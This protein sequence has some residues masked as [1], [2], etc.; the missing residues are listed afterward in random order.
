MTFELKEASV[1]VPKNTG[2]EGFLFT[3]RSI[4]KLPRV[5][6]ILVTGKGVITYKRYAPASPGEDEE[7]SIIFDSMYPWASVRTAEFEELIVSRHN[8]ASTIITMLDATASL[9]MFPLG[10]IVSPATVLWDWYEVTTGYRL[11]KRSTLCGVRVLEDRA[12]PATALVLCASYENSN[13]LVSAD[14]VFK[15]EMDKLGLPREVDIL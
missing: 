15:V 5:Q 13:E 12:V 10:F 2:L 1:T 4:L 11:K 9:E 7:P 3:L 6:E 14:R 8:A